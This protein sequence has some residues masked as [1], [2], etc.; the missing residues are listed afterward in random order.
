M[1]KNILPL[2][3]FISFSLFLSSCDGD[4]L[5]D[6]Q[7]ED[8]ETKMLTAN[9]VDSDL[10]GDWGLSIMET[11]SLVDLNKDGVS[12]QNLLSETTCFNSMSITFN[13][14]KTFSSVNSRMDFKAGET[15]DKFLCM[16]D[17]TDTGT[18]SVEGD[19]LTLNVKIDN[20]IYNHEKK[21]A[22]NG[23]TFSFEVTELESQK[24]VTDPGDTS[25]SSVTVV[26]LEYTKK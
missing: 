23:N 2:F 15:D 7:A 5:D 21:I 10:V 14:D 3:L 12:T 11:D 4:D 17:R 6:L 26:S 24:Y 1:K 9:I 16:D 20:S 19:L 18:W 22:M 13:P 8:L 25:V